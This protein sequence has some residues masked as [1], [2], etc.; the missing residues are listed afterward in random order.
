MNLRSFYVFL[1]ALVFLLMGLPSFADEWKPR[2]DLVSHT[3]VMDLTEPPPPSEVFFSGPASPSEQPG[4]LDGLKNWRRDR[5]TL[6]R[7]DGSQYDR[8]DLQW[9]QRI[10]S[11]VQLLIWDRSFYD[12]EKGEYTVDRFL[13]ETESR[14]GPIDA[15][16]IW[17]VYPN[18]GVDDRN[19]LDLLRDLPG[20]VGGVRG[21]VEQF[22]KRGVRVF[23]PLLVWDTGTRNEGVALSAA[24]AQLLKDIGADGINFDTLESV[25]PGFREAS[26]AIGHPLALEPQ[27]QPRDSSL[28]WTNISWNDWV[29]WEGKQYPFVPMVSKN[30]WMEPRH[31]VNVTDRFTRDK[32]D[33][34]QHAF[35]NGQGY[36]TLENLW[37]FWYEDTAHDAEA[38][39]RF[40]RIE[41]AMADYL[42]SPDWEPH[43]PVLQYGV[44][45]S[46]FPRAN[47]ALWTIVNRNEYGVAGAQI[48]VANE[49][50]LHYYD[51][52]RGA[53]L[54][55]VVIGGAPGA[56]ARAT[57]NFDLEGLGYGA[58]LATKDGLGDNVQKLLAYMADRSKRQ[59]ASY[60][61]EWK[62][63][64]QA[65]VEIP[66]TSAA[67][68][69]PTG[70][71]RIPEGDYD[72]Q[73]SGIEIEGG[74]DPGADV[75]YPWESTARRFHRRHMHMR[76]F[77]IDRTPVTNAEFKK[78]L[79]ATHY[80]P[81]DDHNFLRTWQNGICPQGWEN[82]PVTWVSLED[83]HAYAGWA[84]K[85]L[86]HEW[87]WQYAAQSSDRRPYPWGQEWNSQSVPPADSGSSMKP[88]ADVAAFPQGASPFGVLDMI[89][90]VSQW[91]DEF[92]GPHTRAAI[93]RGAAAYQP[94]GSI[95]YF[96]QTYRLDEHQKYLLMSPGRDRAGTIGFR[97]VVDAQ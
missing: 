11:Q 7:Y 91:T 36:A 73:V 49:P 34:L 75:Q 53:E 81:K 8:P 33:S 68:S 57:L 52:W 82:K 65:L 9:T 37:G 84:H 4:W 26:D 21:M 43:A 86:P 94:A 56:N 29:T 78:F 87:E 28:A 5:R 2:H 74:N 14:I 77:Y 80:H 71:V 62:P 17:H 76:P 39:L 59:L 79:D 67:Q 30:K 40:T 54:K 60:S 1:V 48:E 19:Q 46:R 38:L 3:G 64:P 92:R 96:P 20:G 27:F 89:G 83:A 22:H 13:S 44:F 32:T 45:A 95:W 70:M 47:G 69:A 18:L 12:P 85:R 61:R 88:L 23:F 15:V 50:G 41:R 93:V 90:N 63:A 66:A 35:F 42:T 16:L 31:T 25:P 6:L 97:C 51:L 72:F 10:F 24:M 55:P 58:V